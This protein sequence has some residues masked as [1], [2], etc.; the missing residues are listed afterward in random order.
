MISLFLFSPVRETLQFTTSFRACSHR[1]VFWL[2]VQEVPPLDHQPEYSNAVAHGC[3]LAVAMMPYFVAT[4]KNEMGWHSEGDWGHAA[5]T[6][7][8]VAEQWVSISG[9]KAGSGEMTHCLPTVCQ[10]PLK[11][12]TLYI[13]FQFSS[14]SERRG[15]GRDSMKC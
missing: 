2:M 9:G 13:T 7:A 10:M 15:F 4:A 1:Q 11:S 5:T 6:H 3:T 12:N 14:L 8:M